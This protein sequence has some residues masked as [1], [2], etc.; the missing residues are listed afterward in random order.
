MLPNGRASASVPARSG[1]R[2]PSEEAEPPHVLQ[3][4][5]S[6]DKL[7]LK[8]LYGLADRQLHNFD[9]GHAIGWLVRAA[10]LGYRHGRYYRRPTLEAL[11]PSSQPGDATTTAAQPTGGKPLPPAM[12][13][14]L[15]RL[16][17]IVEAGHM[18]PTS[19]ARLT[20][21]VGAMSLPLPDMTRRLAEEAQRG[22][23]YGNAIDVSMMAQGFARLLYAEPV[24]ALVQVAADR[25]AGF[26]TKS[27]AGMAWAG[28]VVQLRDD[29]SLLALIEE[30]VERGEA[31]D[32][33][34]INHLLYSMARLQ[35]GQSRLL[36]SLLPYV[37]Q[38]HR[39]F[40]PHDLVSSLAALAM[41][42]PLGRQ[43]LAVGWLEED[44]VMRLS[45]QALRCVQLMDATDLAYLAKAVAT[46]AQAGTRADDM[47]PLV[48]VVA[49]QSLRQL[50]QL[51]GPYISGLVWSFAKLQYRERDVLSQLYEE[52]G[53][54]VHQLGQELLA[55][56]L[57][58]IASLRYHHGGIVAR[59]RSRLRDFAPEEV[60]YLTISTTVWAHAVLR[61]QDE[62]PLNGP[63]L[64]QAISR[65]GEAA[66]KSVAHLAWGS[67]LL[68]WPHGDLMEALALDLQRRQLRDLA[69]HDCAN[70]AWGFALAG[71]PEP[72]GV[73]DALSRHFLACAVK[74]LA[75]GE[76]GCDWVAMADALLLCKG[77]GQ[78]LEVPGPPPGSPRAELLRAFDEAIFRPVLRQ[79]QQLS[80]PWRRPAPQLRRRGR[81][82]VSDILAQRERREL[83]TPEAAHTAA[84]NSLSKLA[85]ALRVVDLGFW[86][87]RSAL[88]HLGILADGSWGTGH[89]EGAPLW[90]AIVAEAVQS[91]AH[92]APQMREI[93]AW[94][95]YD[96]AV[97]FGGLEESVQQDGC[98][99]RFNECKE[100]RWGALLRPLHI[101]HDRGGHAERM[102][103]L[104]VIEDFK[105]AENRLRRR[106]LTEGAPAAM[107][108]LRAPESTARG[109][110][111]IF[112]AHTP[113]LSCVASFAQ[114]RRLY[115][116]VT[117]V[118]AFQDSRLAERQAGNRATPLLRCC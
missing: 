87:T 48:E 16:Q 98:V 75:D 99:V 45:V 3:R 14:V 95:A 92:G 20:L 5:I 112:A 7:T 60:T 67:A 105:G 47:E 24:S 12:V 59:L 88:A 66:V 31:L 72:G 37:S 17:P 100:F 36:G 2:L 70:A 25:A 54:K 56:L 84:V 117:L 62:D 96:V 115:P 114:F 103:L 22:A 74:P 51:D 102:A 108:P 32:A 80:E 23:A 73:L 104:G 86:H 11:P 39:G 46:Y 111:R 1:E 85:A 90:P 19:L 107:P 94:I 9:E 38:H 29:G 69:A 4:R 65:V 13:A 68:G 71:L 106:V 55:G 49:S 50:R 6:K 58:S 116:E 28:A 61:V 44:A 91:L 109:E 78:S 34:S 83:A 30:A 82:Q 35:L 33:Q 57:W 76:S 18:H 110:V 53:T 15:Q 8:E 113:C 21:A 63:L 93:V 26:G 42:R 43:Q 97:G 64:A 52:A 81:L 27:L 77:G 118:V 79:L 10:K 89:Q 40:S 41:L 101:D